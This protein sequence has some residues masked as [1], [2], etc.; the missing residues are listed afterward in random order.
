MEQN[1]RYLGGQ[2]C[3]VLS[4]SQD[5]LPGFRSTLL[6]KAQKEFGNMDE[7]LNG[8]KEEIER[9]L[10]FTQFMSEIFL[11]LLLEKPDKS[12][13]RMDV[14]GRAILGVVE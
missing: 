6:G 5:G 7:A 4:R 9:A 10:G 13:T 8:S 2:L 14:L 1:F 11:S 3:H 12:L